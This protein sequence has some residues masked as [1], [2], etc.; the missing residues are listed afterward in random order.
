[1]AKSLLERTAGHG[2]D[3]YHF[4]DVVRSGEAVQLNHKILGG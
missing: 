1:M 2:T 4:G 3:N